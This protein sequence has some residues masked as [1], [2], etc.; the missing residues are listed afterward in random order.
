MSVHITF[1]AHSTTLDNEAKKASGWYDVDLSAL[2]KEQAAE[3]GLRMTNETFDAI[4]CSDLSRSFDTAAIAFQGRRIPIFKDKRL[5]EC[6]YGDLTR[7]PS[8]EIEH[9]KLLHL[10]EPFPNGESYTDTNGRMKNFLDFL[11][12]EYGEKRVLI[13]GHRATQYALDYFIK[14]IPM[15]ELLIAKFVWQPLWSYIWTGETA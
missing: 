7:A 6:N 8:Q 13:V 2:G 14:G 12:K 15:E 10:S 5:R 9:S 1:V 4:F 11:L 3:L